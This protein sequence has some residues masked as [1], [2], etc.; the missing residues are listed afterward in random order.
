MKEEYAS[1]V[2]ALD[3]PHP[4]IDTDA[5]LADMPTTGEGVNAVQHRLLRALIVRE[6]KSPQEAL[7]IVVD[8][9]ME[10]A[11]RERLA[12]ENGRPWTREHEIKCAVP[13]LNWV[14]RNL[15]KQHWTAV[16]N[17]HISAD[18]PPDWLWPEA[19]E[20][21]T[22]ACTEGIRPQISRNAN[23]WYV[24][25]PPYSAAK[26]APASS[27]ASEKR[28]T[29]SAAAARSA[30]NRDAV[31]KF[32]RLEFIKRFDIAS[33]PPRE[34]LYG[35]HYQ[36]GVVSGTVAPGGRGKSSLVM[37]EAV[38]MATCRN[39]LGEQ[40]TARLRVWYHNGEDDMA[41]LQRR[42]AAIC[43]HYGIPTA[44]LEGW[45]CVTSSNEFP[46]QV[47][48]GYRDLIPN[49]PLIA[50]LAVEIER[51]RFDQA[52][53]DPLVTLH[54]T[55]EIEPGNMN[56]VVGIFKT[57]AA[58]QQCGIELVAHTRKPAAGAAEDYDI[59]DMRGTTAIRDALRAV[60]LLNIMSEKEANDAGIEE[61][62][63]TQ[64]VRIDRGKGNYSPPTKAVWVRFV[65]AELPNGDDVGV[66]VPWTHPGQSGKPSEAMLAI[67]QKAEETFLLLL[68]K[69]RAA[70][71]H[72][73]QGVNSPYYA[74]KVFAKEREAREAKLGQA[75]FSA[76]MR[77]LFETGRIRIGT[78]MG[79]NR[80]GRET[81]VAALSCATS[82]LHLRYMCALSVPHT[83]YGDL[84]RA[85]SIKRC[86]VKS[87]QRPASGVPK[88][89][90]DTRRQEGR[91][92]GFGSRLRALG[93]KSRPRVDGCAALK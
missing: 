86:C 57:L 35:R 91:K 12:D 37:V 16:D 19:H 40:P 68:A 8:A 51:N 42:L 34:W 24:R 1:N 92:G 9:T 56:R 13:R 7:D 62:E 43:Q 3:V 46:L 14:L 15:E 74:P 59:N 50:H 64:Y 88:G 41:E 44:E 32:P 71:R 84:A 65:D 26:E 80:H 83:P 54:G 53:M 33:I 18:V 75:H 89:T 48:Q 87:S 28:A 63:R 11:Q 93:N 60:R 17:G 5:V 31:S 52:T 23:G 66:I 67:E 55:N 39:L 4:P 20:P 82:A 81:I 27:I 73:S 77:R 47:A 78:E 76:A 85:R 36:R 49:K 2:V 22:V 6:G 38:A 58:E 25:R 21:W 61:F 90:R 79:P 10:M 30:N 72:V 29:T 70:G 69:A 45:L